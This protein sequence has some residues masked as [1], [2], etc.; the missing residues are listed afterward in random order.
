[1]FNV[2]ATTITIAVMI[3]LIVSAINIGIKEDKEG[4]DTDV[5]I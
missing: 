2:L 4:G 1:M 3:L 5:G